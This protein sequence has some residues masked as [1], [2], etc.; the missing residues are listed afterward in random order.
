MSVCFF[1]FQSLKNDNRNLVLQVFP[2]TLNIA[3]VRNARASILKF[4]NK[5]IN[6]LE[7]LLMIFN[8]T[9]KVSFI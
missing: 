2:I 8:H 9:F 1:H 7:P 4:D 3:S 6:K 5:K